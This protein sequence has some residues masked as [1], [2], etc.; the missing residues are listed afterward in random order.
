MDCSPPGSSVHEILQARILEWVAISISGAPIGE[1]RTGLLRSKGGPLLHF[2]P[3][4]MHVYYH[5]SFPLLCKALLLLDC[6]IVSHSAIIALLILAYLIC[7]PKIFPS[8]QMKYF[9]FLQNT[10]DA[11]NFQQKMVQDR[12]QH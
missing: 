9:P 7:T 8:G 5:Q 12:F 3:P 2:P 11:D 4:A 1:I 6:L 10:K